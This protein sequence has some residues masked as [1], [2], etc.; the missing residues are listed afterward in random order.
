MKGVTELK[1]V[2]LHS[3]AHKEIY[4]D[5]D[6]T[7]NNFLNC[8]KLTILVVGKNLT[9]GDGMFK[10]HNQPTMTACVNIY[11]AATSASDGTINLNAANNALLTGNIYY[12]SESEAENCW[13]YDVNCNAALYQIA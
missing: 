7:D 10:F 8:G 11:T 6:F 13:H 4:P 3:L 1:R 12:Y 2:T 5:N 9:V